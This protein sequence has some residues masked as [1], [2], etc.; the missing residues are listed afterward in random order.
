MNEVSGQLTPE[1]ME[2]LVADFNLDKPVVGQFFEYIK[3]IFTLNLGMSFSK[4]QPIATLLAQALP[5]TILLA[6]S[7]LVLSTL[8]GTALGAFS[9]YLRKK[10]RDFPLIMAITVL[11]AFPTF[12]IGMVLLSVFGVGL[13]WFPLFGA[14]SMWGASGSAFVDVLRH[15][16]MPLTTL[17]LVTVGIFFTTSRYSVLFVLEQDYIKMARARGIS[18]F[19]INTQY[20]V[21]N[22]LIP[23]F[24]LLMMEAGFIFSGAVVI[25][26]LFSYPG[27]GLLLYDAVMARDYPLMQYSFLL[28]S[29][30]VIFAAFLADVLNGVI[31]PTM[32]N[33]YEK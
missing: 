18:R 6:V 24:T 22:S 8:L 19:R 33:A 31:D 17:V 28:T 4:N 15:L 13:R 11:G 14:Y 23:V 25:E 32:R 29:L 20:I 10:R 3:D 21:R 1:Q 9:A 12:W 26:K 5:W 16:A 27:I 30:T 7:N 2:R